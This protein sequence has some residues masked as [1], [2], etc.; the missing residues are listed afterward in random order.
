MASTTIENPILVGCGPVRLT[1][2]HSR[3]ADYRVVVEKLQSKLP[4]GTQ[5]FGFHI[6]D[7]K[8]DTCRCCLYGVVLLPTALTDESPALT[9][10][11]ANLRDVVAE[12][13]ELE[14]LLV[15]EE[16]P[17]SLLERHSDIQWE[18]E[19]YPK[20]DNALRFIR[21]FTKKLPFYKVISR[22]GLTLFGRV[23]FEYDVD[24]Q[25]WREEYSAD[26]VGGYV[27][28]LKRV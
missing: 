27:L 2:Q 6:P 20:G 12:L 25:R 26:P 18:V 7:M 23:M 13:T 10:W 22:D 24:G 8:M 15:Q 16:S 11:R 14:R 17:T 4:E 28:S 1:L 21:M 9:E 3:I 19:S 5:F